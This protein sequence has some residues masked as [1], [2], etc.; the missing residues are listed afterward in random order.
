MDGITG[1]YSPHDKDLVQ[2]VFLATGA[3]QHRG[4]ASAG[5]AVGGAKGL[6]I[7]KGVGGIVD[8]ADE[9]ILQIFQD[10]EPVAAIGNVGYTKNKIPEKRNAEPILVKPKRASRYT[11]A[12]TMNGR[13]LEDDEL[14]SELEDDYV[15]DTVNKTE[16]MGALLHRFIE[17]EGL[18]F[19]AGRKLVDLLHGW[20]TFSLTA[21]VHDGA[22]TALIALN[23]TRA[24]EPFCFGRVGDGFLAS[25]ESCSHRRLGGHPEREYAGAEMTIC[26]ARGIETRRLRVEAAMP[27]AFQPVYFGNSASRY[28][29]EEI[30]RLRMGLG[31]ALTKLYASDA[32]VVIPN[33]DSGRGVS[34]GIAEGLRKPL[35]PGLVK[36]AQ[37]IRTFQEAGRSQRMRQVAV[38]FAAMDSV[39]AG[40]AIIMGDDS[41]VKGSVSEGGAVWSVYNA[42]ATRLEFWVSYG[43]MFFPSFKE[44]R[45]GRECLDELAVQRAF[46][47]DNPYDKTT[48]EINAR[49]ARLLGVDRVCYNTIENVQAVIGPG[50]YQALDA[51][52]PISE[53][54]W[55]DWLKQEVEHF[56]HYR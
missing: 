3:L 41:I 14:Q 52:Y 50:C 6:Y 33:P 21:L 38:K 9:G 36:Q 13:I 29:G 51:S 28:Q 31:R 48:E 16:V 8:V 10:L 23:D 46:R 34:C 4:K 2:K 18:G 5:L 49:V 43:P 54:F 27:D 20:A 1:C 37:A 35:Y 56:R 32:D 15:F 19:A 44:W 26:S 45:R 25:S 47:G 17:Q 11:L 12:L 30:F 53:R 39:L 7:H 24:F 55:P 42:G 22:E 40:R